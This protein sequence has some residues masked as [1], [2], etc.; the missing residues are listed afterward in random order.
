VRPDAGKAV[1]PSPTAP[2]PTAPEAQKRRRFQ[3]VIVATP[4]RVYISRM[5]NH[6]GRDGDPFDPEGFPDRG[7][8][9]SGILID[10]PDNINKESV[11]RRNG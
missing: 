6:E 4:S 1:D 11:A 2:I 3:A 9:S 10:R 8:P 5:E 7:R